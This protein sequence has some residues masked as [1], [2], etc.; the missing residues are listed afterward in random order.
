MSANA[1]INASNDWL[2]SLTDKGRSDSRHGERTVSTKT[3]AEPAIMTAQLLDS[4]ACTKEPL[5][6]TSRVWGLYNIC[7]IFV[8]AVS[9]STT[10]YYLFWKTSDLTPPATPVAKAAQPATTSAPA[11]AKDAAPTPSA[12]PAPALT[13]TQN[14]TPTQ[15][16]VPLN[17]AEKLE[18][19]VAPQG[20]ADYRTIAEAVA[21]SKSGTRIRVRPGTYPESIAIDKSL[22]IVGDGNANEIVVESDNNHALALRADGIVLRNISVRTKAAGKNVEFYPIHVTQGQ[23]LIENCNV[24]SQ[25]LSGV[26]VEGADVNP[27][28]RNCVVRDCAGCGVFFAARAKGQMIG[29]QIIGSTQAGIVVSEGARPLVVQ[30]ASSGGKDAGGVVNANCEPTFLSCTFTGNALA[31]VLVRG[32]NAKV[33][34]RD[35]TISD[36]RGAGLFVIDKSSGVADGCT[37][38]GNTQSNVAVNTS[39]NATITHCRLLNG[40]NA[41]VFVMSASATVVGCEIDGCDDVGIAV[42]K[43]GAAL[44]SSTNI[45]NCRNGAWVVTPDSVVTG[46]ANTPPAP[47]R[48][49]PPS[50][51]IRPASPALNPAPANPTLP[52]PLIRK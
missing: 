38:S 34:F 42:E 10:A 39:G 30:C 24:T 32:A 1:T 40:R 22:E 29:C 13:P 31:G 8:M 33:L 37:I 16:A 5:A 6:K 46:L 28:I 45:R 26:F 36:N 50:N 4:T 14:P 3:I 27:T 51:T 35:C 20:D 19:V 11:P 41:G 52:N 18:V 17:P 44:V 12:D 23:P 49:N 25:S 9:L 48:A 21:R 2:A 7:A 47:T 43:N 15:P